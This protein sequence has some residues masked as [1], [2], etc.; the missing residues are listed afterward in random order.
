M[1]LVMKFTEAYVNTHAN[2]LFSLSFWP[3]AS[4][5]GIWDLELCP[6][7]IKMPEIDTKKQK[8]LSFNVDCEHQEREGQKVQVTYISGGVR[9]LRAI[10]RGK[11]WSYLRKQKTKLCKWSRTKKRKTR[12]LQLTFQD[13]RKEELMR[14]AQEHWMWFKLAV[15]QRDHSG[16]QLRSQ[17]RLL[18]NQPL[19]SLGR[20]RWPIFRRVGGE[21]VGGVGEGWGTAKARGNHLPALNYTK[22]LEIGPETETR[23]PSWSIKNSKKAKFSLFP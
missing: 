5:G 6:A 16:K 3:V 22:P 1:Q 20:G 17:Q 21:L 2:K 11:W 12:N 7:R 19:F 23:C 8:D 15:S 18:A 9:C 13:I 14:C 10:T 4:V